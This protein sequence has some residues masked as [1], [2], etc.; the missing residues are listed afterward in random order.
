MEVVKEDIKPTAH[1][2]KS[3]YQIAWIQF[4]KNRLAYYSLWF[5]IFLSLIAIFADFLA[6]NKPII[7]QYKEQ[8]Y[9]PIFYDYADALGIYKWDNELRQL[10]WKEAELKFAIWPLV[11]YAPEEIDLRNAQSVGPFEKQDIRSPWE[12]HWLGTDELGR[13]LLSGLIHGTRISLTVGIIS[14]GLSAIIG[15]ILGAFAGYFGDHRLRASRASILSLFIGLPLAYYYG[16]MIRSYTL[17]AALSKSFSFFLLH[18]T[19]STVIFFFILTL[20]WLIFRPLKKIPWFRVQKSLWIDITISR[21]IEVMVSIPTLLL[22]VSVAAIAKPSIFLVMAIIGLTSWTRIAR[23]TR[24]ELL[25]VRNLEYI[26]AAQVMGF[27]ELRII[28]RHALPNS[29]APVFIAIAFGIASAI[30]IES[31]LSFLGIGVPPSTVTWGSLLASARDSAS[32]WWLAIFPGFAIFFTVTAFNL[33]GEGL[34][35]A[36]DPR[37][38]T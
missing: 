16:F 7:A 23:F 26:Q 3:F 19:L 2:S 12:R 6:Y 22:I 1:I 8:I 35:D 15:I 13:D 4:K 33:F 28:F 18:L 32:A 14:T 24:G 5:L 38:K 20:V 25:R 9:F 11:R 30:L 17:S 36:L 37:L 21:F 34:R 29:L 27:S 31:S 10:N